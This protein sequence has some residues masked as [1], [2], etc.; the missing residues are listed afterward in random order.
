MTTERRAIDYSELEIRAADDG[1]KTIEG[2]AIKWEKL[3]VPLGY[4]TRYREKFSRS[5]FAEYLRADTDTKF[6]VGHDINQVLGRRKNN[7][8]TLTEDEEGLRFRLVLPA[9]TAG[10]DIYES[11]RRGDVDK[12][13]VGF[14]KLGEEWDETDENNPVRTVTKANLPEI[15]LTAWPAYEDTEATARDSDP[16]QRR[17]KPYYRAKNA[18]RLLKLDELEG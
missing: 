17:E 2:Y 16:Y 6:L 9:T 13:S 8:L 10:A 1:E 5:A 11:I 12:I 18:I 4:F 15:S 7:T 3:S 14:N